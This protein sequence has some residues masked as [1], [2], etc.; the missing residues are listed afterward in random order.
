[1]KVYYKDMDFITDTDIHLQHINGSTDNE[2]MMYCMYV[3]DFTIHAKDINTITQLIKNRC[4]SLGY[5][6]EYGCCGTNVLIR[7]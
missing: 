3:R 6:F 5:R 1:M 7:I 4:H 2:F